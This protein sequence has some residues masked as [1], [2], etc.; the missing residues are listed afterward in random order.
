[1]DKVEIKLKN[2]SVKD[3]LALKYKFTYE[4]AYEFIEPKNLING[5]ECNINELL[6]EEVAAI[7]M[8]YSN[9]NID[10]V[11]MLFSI[12]YKEKNVLTCGVLEF[13][14][15]KKWLDIEIDALLKREKAMLNRPADPKMLAAGVQNLNKFGIANTTVSLGAQFGCEPRKVLRWKYV[16]VLIIQAINVTTGEIQRNLAKQK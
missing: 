4:Q 9:S 3:Y 1:M 5:K 2:I 7:K 16:D 6:F 13:F 12:C 14:Q 8:L 15:S 10:K 11:K